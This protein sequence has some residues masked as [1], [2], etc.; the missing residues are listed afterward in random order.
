MEIRLYSIFDKASEEYSPIF[1]AVNDSVAVRQFH[2]AMKDN[3]FPSD[4]KLVCLGS[5]HF[6]GGNAGVIVNTV[7]LDKCPYDVDL[8]IRD[9]SSSREAKDE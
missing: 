3:P 9:I 2:F 5:F 1:Q 7:G 8:S 6:S 4:Y